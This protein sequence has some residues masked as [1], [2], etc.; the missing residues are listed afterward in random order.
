VKDV[1]KT[2]RFLDLGDFL[3]FKSFATDVKIPLGKLAF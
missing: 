1:D 3:T 2:H